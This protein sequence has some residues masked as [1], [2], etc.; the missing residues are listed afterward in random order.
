[1]NIY[2]TA[3]QHEHQ[4]QRAHRLRTEIARLQRQV[5][6]DGETDRLNGALAEARARRQELERRLREVDRDTE[7][8][9]ARATARERELMSGHIGSPAGLM[10]LREEVE[11]LQHALQGAEDAELALL[12]DADRQDEELHTLERTLEQRSA[13]VAGASPQLKQ[14]LQAADEELQRV[15][16][17][18]RSTW[19]EL[20]PDWQEAIERIHRHHGDAVAEVADGLCGACHVAV[21]SSGRQALRRGAMLTCDNCGRLLVPA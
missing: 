21:T 12:E 2:G 20:P 10:K 18:V 9:R 6:G 13:E 1:M 5:A 7:E 14:R 3:L 17:E 19:D 11:H 16:A 4:T 8:R 15:E